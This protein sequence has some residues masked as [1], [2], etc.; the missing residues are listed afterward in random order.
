MLDQEIV[1]AF[2][3]PKVPMLRPWLDRLNLLDVFIASV[4]GIWL[5]HVQIAQQSCAGSKLA[6]LPVFDGFGSG[7]TDAGYPALIQDD[8]H[9][10]SR[11]LPRRSIATSFS[12]SAR[13]HEIMQP[14]PELAVGV[15]KIKDNAHVVEVRH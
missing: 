9:P 12:C 8:R 2:H 3:N 1:V 14:P 10:I 15:S 4:A 5:D 6:W 11:Q 13:D 7:G